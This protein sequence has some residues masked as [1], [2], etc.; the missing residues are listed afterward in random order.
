MSFEVKDL[1]FSY[2][3]QA[4]LNQ[5][6]F[7]VQSGEFLSILGRNGA[8]KSTL[9]RCMLGLNPKYTGTIMMDGK[10]IK[11]LSNSQLA[12][13]IAYIPQAHYQAF[14]YSVFTMVLM[15]TSSQVSALS[16]PGSAQKKRAEDALARVGIARLAKKSFAHISGG[17]RQLVLIARAL[18]QDAKT[19]ILDEPTAHLDYGNQLRVMQQLRSLVDDGYT[20]IS[21]THSPEHAFLF[22]H[23]VL[24]LKDGTAWVF[25]LPSDTITSGLIKELYDADVE[26]N[27]LH[28]GR[29][30]VFV[31]KLY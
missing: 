27:N 5:L 21:S 25:G 4:V 8:G 20:V 3:S 18:A 15:G 29:V 24:V 17:E 30:R 7:T 23:H 13:H 22:S 19:L 1:C 14:S 28:D 2:G 26:E 6:S 31:P 12:R 11:T 10:D 16:S 9:L